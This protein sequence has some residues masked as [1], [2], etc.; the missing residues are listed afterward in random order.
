MLD[1]GFFGRTSDLAAIADWLDRPVSSRPVT[2][3][4]ISGLPGIGKSSLVDEAARRAASAATAWIVVRLDFDRG[5]LDVQDRV[6]L[7]LEIGRQVAIEL[8]ESAAS[9]RQARLVAAGATPTSSPDVKGWG[10]ERVPDELAKAL[11]AAIESSGRP[12][13]MML[14]T[15][16][17]LRERGDTHPA[18]LFDC[19]DELCDRGL[20]PLAVISAGRGDALDCAPERIGWRVDLEGLDP[21]AAEALL[22][23]LD[24]PTEAATQITELA[25]GN[26]LVLRLAAL[27]VREAGPAVLTHAQGRRELAAAYLYR[28]LLSRITDPVLRRLAQPGLLVRRI[29]AE[30]IEQVLIPQLGLGPPTPG[31]SAD[32]FDKLATHHWL[33]EPDATPGWVRHRAD[34]RT[35][36]L[37]QLY[38]GESAT[39]AARINKAAAKWYAGRTEP[40]AVVEAAYHQLQ[41]MRHGGQAPH[42]D[43]SVLGQLDS[44]TI[45]ELPQQAQDLILAAR[46]QRTSKFRIDSDAS[47]PSTS[48]T[49]R[50]IGGDARRGSEGTRAVAGA[51]GPRR[52]TPCVLASVRTSPTSIRGRPRPALLAPSS[53]APVGGSRPPS[54]FAGTASSTVATRH[55]AWINHRW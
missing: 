32:L 46:G 31:Q 6:G 8:G 48:A 20:R 21:V 36:L 22:V 33:V 1:R 39:T 42:I 9:L 51:R 37:R 47:R 16:E 53:G 29:S 25:D 45:A 49:S 26:P 44:T 4:F 27:A 54:T 5:G 41:A 30:V 19:I 3:L 14:D 7:T 17:V 11:G 13:L 43:P 55:S 28:F 24:V 50:P 52:G 15:L 2:A 40:F 12:V 18:R 35:M 10:R 34:I 38:E 23:S